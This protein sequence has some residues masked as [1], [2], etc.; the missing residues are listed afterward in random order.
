M[1]ETKRFLYKRGDKPAVFMYGKPYI[2]A[3]NPKGVIVDQEAAKLNG[4]GTYKVRPVE[5]EVEQKTPIKNQDGSITQGTRKVT[6]MLETLVKVDDKPSRW[7][8]DIPV[9]AIPLLLSAGNLKEYGIKD[10]K[11][12]RVSH[13]FEE[14]DMVTELGDAAVEQKIRAD[15]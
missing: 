6:A 13:A 14:M 5:Q 15:A 3:P 7:Y 1:A 8:C 4:P 2:F 9:E 12:G 10:P 11:T